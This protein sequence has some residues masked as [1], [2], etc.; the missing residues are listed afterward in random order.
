M[1]RLALLAVV[2]V[3]LSSAPAQTAEPAPVP[4]AQASVQ[5]AGRIVVVYPKDWQAAVTGAGTVI[6]IAGP[7]ATGARPSAVILLTRGHGDIRE[8]LD[9]AARG[10]QAIGKVQLLGEQHLS[11][12]RWTRYYVRDT[13]RAVEYVVVGVAQHGGWIATLVAIDAAQ[14]PELRVRAAIFERMLANLVMPL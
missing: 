8:I 13:N 10:V 7:S 1:M 12:S 9:S 3:L 14:D 11:A 6:G 4:T 5:A 2:I